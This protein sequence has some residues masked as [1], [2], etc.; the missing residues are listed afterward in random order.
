MSGD[1]QRLYEGSDGVRVSS[2]EHEDGD[3]TLIV[4]QEGHES[5]FVRLPAASVPLLSSHFL[6]YSWVH[7]MRGLIERMQSVTAKVEAAT[8]RAK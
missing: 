5:G 8:E 2:I 4:A 1:V 7:A 3:V 6:H